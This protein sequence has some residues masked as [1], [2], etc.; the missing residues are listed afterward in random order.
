MLKHYH[1]E[2]VMIAGLDEAGR[3]CFAGPVCAAAVILPGNYRNKV[4]K[5]S[6]QLDLQMWIFLN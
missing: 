6:K 4:L 3:G 1:K 5:D 2:G